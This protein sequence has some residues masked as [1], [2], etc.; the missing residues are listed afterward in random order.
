MGYVWMARAVTA[1]LFY[2]NVT[3][4]LNFL[5]DYETRTPNCQNG[6]FFCH[7]AFQDLLPLHPM[8]NYEYFNSCPCILGNIKLDYHFLCL[9]TG[10]FKLK[11]SC[12]YV[13]P[14]LNKFFWNGLLVWVLW[15]TARPRDV[16]SALSCYCNCFKPSVTEGWKSSCLIKVCSKNVRLQLVDY[17]RTDIWK[18]EYI[19][20]SEGGADS[21]ELKI[22]LLIKFN[23]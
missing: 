18:P 21:C 11:N 5:L 12:S 14:P 6:K 7:I 4:R 2:L 10:Y 13:S 17:V 9:L 15:R 22:C 1:S 20:I 3:F 19:Q 16:Y 23:P 8:E